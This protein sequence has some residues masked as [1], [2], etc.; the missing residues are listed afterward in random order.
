MPVRAFYPD[1]EVAC[2]E[3]VG[4]ALEIGDPTEDVLDFELEV[5]A[6]STST[7][8]RTLGTSEDYL[9]TRSRMRKLRLSQECAS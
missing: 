2:L 8:P 9:S 5:F 1:V 7:A 6:S 4:L 3:S